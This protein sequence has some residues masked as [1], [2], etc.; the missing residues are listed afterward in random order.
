MEIEMESHAM[1]N[2]PL[3]ENSIQHKTQRRNAPIYVRGML[4]KKDGKTKPPYY[5]TTS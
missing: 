4:K 3:R 2:A 5:P 1:Q